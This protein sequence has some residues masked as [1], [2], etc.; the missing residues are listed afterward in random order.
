MCL[1][2]WPVDEGINR[3]LNHQGT[4]KCLVGMPCKTKSYQINELPKINNKYCYCQSSQNID[5]NMYVSVIVPLKKT[6]Y[7][8][9]FQYHVV[10]HQVM[11]LFSIFRVELAAI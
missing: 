10:T 2:I 4:L 3:Y 9:Q 1:L 8:Y 11:V 6:D 5:K 7:C